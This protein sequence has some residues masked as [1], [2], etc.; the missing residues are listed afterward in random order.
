M[1][2]FMIVFEGDHPILCERLKEKFPDHRE[3]FSRAIVI[4]AE[5]TAQS[6]L[7]GLEL[8]DEERNSVVISELA[9]NY[10]GYSNKSFWDWLGS[11]FRKLANG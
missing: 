2:V 9:A 7:L 10:W 5:G 6:I 1:S 3:V 4:S 8:P 11:R